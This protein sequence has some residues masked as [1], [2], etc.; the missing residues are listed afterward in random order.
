[1]IRNLWPPRRLPRPIRWLNSLIKSN[2]KR[3]RKTK[4]VVILAL[5]I[6]RL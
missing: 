5:R 3:R 2:F 6:M 4:K 1:M